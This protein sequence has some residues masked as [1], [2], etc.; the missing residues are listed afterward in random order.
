MT[1]NTLNIKTENRHSYIQLSDIKMPPKLVK[2][3][4][5]RPSKIF[6]IGTY[7]SPRALIQ[8]LLSK[9]QTQMKEWR[10]ATST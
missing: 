1:W 8:H 2:S 6:F 3:Q 10:Q 9:W 5:K 4:S 7:L